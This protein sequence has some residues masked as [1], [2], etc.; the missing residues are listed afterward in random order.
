VSRG[1]FIPRSRR[2]SMDSQNPR[3]S[4][5]I[6]QWRPRR[7]IYTLAAK[8]EHGYEKRDSRRVT[9]NRIRAGELR[10]FCCAD[11][12]GDFVAA[13][14]GKGT[15]PTGRAHVPVSVEAG[16]A[17]PRGRR[18]VLGYAEGKSKVGR[19][20]IWPKAQV[21]FLFFILF[22]FCFYFQLNSLLNLSLNFLSQIK[23]TIEIQHD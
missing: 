16:R 11:G 6:R 4:S 3:R 12:G 7:P 15:S 5:T 21:M 23:C 18:K 13:D 1:G 2:I 19:R 9:R 22:L 10:F 14:L 20:K 17:G 8:T